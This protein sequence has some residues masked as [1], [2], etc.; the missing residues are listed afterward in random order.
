LA[1]ARAG[2]FTADK[3]NMHAWTNMAAISEFLPVQLETRED[4]G[5]T[6]VKVARFD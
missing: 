5:F 6:G 1:L 3:V 4:D 2:P